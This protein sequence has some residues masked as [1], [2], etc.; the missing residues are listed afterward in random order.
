VRHPLAKLSEDDVREIREFL[1][2]GARPPDIAKLYGVTA[3][4]IKS[5]KYNK[6][7]KT[8]ND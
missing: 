8:V 3:T 7:W 4:P 5:I 2:L 6:A 1:A